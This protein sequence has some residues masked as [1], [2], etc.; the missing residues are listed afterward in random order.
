M[1]LY[2]KNGNKRRKLVAEQ[3]SGRKLV[4][5]QAV[6]QILSSRQELKVNSSALTT[7]VTFSL[8]GTILP[9]DTIGQGDDINQRSGDTVLL[10]Y[11]R[12]QITGFEPTVNRSSTWRVLLFSDS[13]ANGAAPSVTDVLDSAV[14]A[15]PYNGVN[16]QRK[17]FKFLFDRTLTMVGG[18]ANQ[19]AT[20]IATVPLNIKRFYNNS[21]A[22]ST[23]IGKGALFALI[24]SSNVTTSLYSWCHQIRYTDS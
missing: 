11:L 15:A 24:I 23:N 21:S 16:E 18:N 1:A 14:F 19:E 7:G 12:F 22:T 13:M 10:K 8:T 9:L 3:R 2:A 17:R 4:S 6:K 5:K 20:A